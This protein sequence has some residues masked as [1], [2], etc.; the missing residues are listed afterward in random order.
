MQVDILQGQNKAR[1]IRYV[2][3]LIPLITEYKKKLFRN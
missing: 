2:L 1:L 3:W